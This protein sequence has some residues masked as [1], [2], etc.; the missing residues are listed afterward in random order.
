MADGQGEISSIGVKLTLDTSD[1]KKNMQ[2]AKADTTG[3]TAQVEK[4]ASGAAQM[5]AQNGKRYGKG[6]SNL[7]I[8]VTLHVSDTQLKSLKTQ[9]RMALQGIPVTIQPVMPKSGQYSSANVLGAMLTMQYGLSPTAGRNAAAQSLKQILPGVDKKA[10]GGSVAANKPVIVGDGGR[11]EVFVPKTPGMIHPSIQQFYRS[12]EIARRRE[13]ETVIAEQSLQQQHERQV[14]TAMRGVRG[15]S[16]GRVFSRELIHPTRTTNFLPR[17]PLRGKDLDLIQQYLNNGPQDYRSTLYNR[18]YNSGHGADQMWQGMIAKLHD[19][20]SRIGGYDMGF[21]TAPRGYDPNP[22][23]HLLRSLAG[24]Y[25]LP[26]FVPSNMD[27][28]IGQMMAEVQ[29]AKQQAVR[30][31][32]PDDWLSPIGFFHASTNVPGILDRGLMTGEELRKSGLTAGLG[33]NDKFVSTTWSLARAKQIASSLRMAG[34]AARHEVKPS[35]LANYFR[36]RASS[37]T[38]AEGKPLDLMKG[39]APKNSFY[40]EFDDLESLAKATISK[41]RYQGSSIEYDPYFELFKDLDDT[42]SFAGGGG[43]RTEGSYFFGAR[44]D[45]LQHIMPRN[46]GVVQLAMR[47]PPRRM[48]HAALRGR[49]PID[50]SSWSFENSIDYKP[51]QTKGNYPYGEWAD[52][53]NEVNDQSEWMERGIKPAEYE[54]R[55]PPQ[56]LT[57]LGRRRLGG[58]VFGNLRDRYHPDALG[59]EM[60]EESY[61]LWN[62][63]LK[64]KPRGF[65]FATETRGL[66]AAG[67]VCQRALTTRDCPLGHTYNSEG[68][69]VHRTGHPLDGPIVDVYPKGDSR[70][71]GWA[72][73]AVRAIERYPYPAGVE[74]RSDFQ[75]KGLGSWMY[76]EAEKAMYEQ[77]VRDPFIRPSHISQTPFAKAMWANPRR[78]FGGDPDAVPGQTGMFWP[79]RRWPHKAAGGAWAKK[80][81][82]ARRIEARALRRFGQT[83]MLSEAGYV[84]PRGTFIDF[85][86]RSEVGEGGYLGGYKRRGRFWETADPDAEDIF[87]GHRDIDHRQASELFDD[88]PTGKVYGHRSYNAGMMRMLDE[89][90]Y[91]S[92]DF[93]GGVEGQ[94]AGT[95]GQPFTR[96]QREAILDAAR[97]QADTSNLSGLFDLTYQGKDVGMIGSTSFDDPAIPLERAMKM[98]N[99]FYERLGVKRGM[100][101]RIKGAMAGRK[102]VPHAGDRMP[103]SWPAYGYDIDR[104]MVRP[105]LKNYNAMRD[106]AQ[107]DP[108]NEFI[109]NIWYPGRRRALLEAADA[110]GALPRG[111]GFGSFLRAARNVIPVAAAASPGISDRKAATW[112]HALNRLFNDPAKLQEAQELAATRFVKLRDQYIQG[113]KRGTL[114]MDVASIAATGEELFGERLTGGQYGWDG[115]LKAARIARGDVPWRQALRTSDKVMPFT[116]NLMGN[117][118]I[119]TVDSHDFDIAG[120]G[121]RKGHRLDQSKYATRYSQKYPE[122]RPNLLRAHLLEAARLSQEGSVWGAQRRHQAGIWVPHFALPEAGGGKGQPIT[123]AV[124]NLVVPKGYRGQIPP[125]WGMDDQFR[126]IPMAGGGRAK[127]AAPGWLGAYLSEDALDA[128]GYTKEGM[129]EAGQTRLGRDIV[130]QPLGRVPRLTSSAQW[131]DLMRTNRTGSQAIGRLAPRHAFFP[132]DTQRGPSL[133]RLFDNPDPFLHEPWRADMPYP[134]KPRKMADGG[135]LKRLWGRRPGKRPWSML[136][137]MRLGQVRDVHPFIPGRHDPNYCA[138]DG[139]GVKRELHMSAMGGERQEPGEAPDW[140]NLWTR[141]IG[142]I[143]P[144]KYAPAL[145]G[146]SYLT[147]AGPGSWRTGLRKADPDF[148]QIKQEEHGTGTWTS[149]FGREMPEWNAHQ[150][151]PFLKT[152]KA[153]PK[154]FSKMAGG[155]RALEG[156]YL[157]GEIGK[158]LFVPD[159]MAHMVPKKVMDQIPRAKGGMQVIGTKRDPDLGGELFFPPSDGVII[160]NR[161]M[162]QVPRAAAGAGGEEWEG[163]GWEGEYIPGRHD[164]FRSRG[165]FAQPRNAGQ[166]FGGPPGEGLMGTPSLYRGQEFQNPRFSYYQNYSGVNAAQDWGARPQVPLGQLADEATGQFMQSHRPMP[167]AGILPGMRQATSASSSGSGSPLPVNVMNWPS[168]LTPSTATQPPVAAPPSGSA[169]MT[170]TGG[171]DANSQPPGSSSATPPPVPSSIDYM[172]AQ[173]GGPFENRSGLVPPAQRKIK[174]NRYGVEPINMV[175]GAPGQF[176]RVSDKPA[177]MP[178]DYLTSQPAGPFENRSGLVA[179]S[180]ATATKPQA[181]AS[182]EGAAFAAQ[183]MDTFRQRETELYAAGTATSTRTPQGLVAMISAGLPFLGGSNADQQARVREQRDAMRGLERATTAVFEADT[184]KGAAWGNTALE[185]VA[186]EDAL[187]DYLALQD[188]LV[189]ARDDE[190]DAIKETMEVMKDALPELGDLA[191]AQDKNAAAIKKSLPGLSEQAGGLIKVVAGIQLYSMA[192]QG[193]GFAMSAGR[194][195]AA[196]L[197]D[198]QR[199]WKSISIQTTTALADQT[200]AQSGNVDAAMNQQAASILLGGSLS[201]L[202]TEILRMPVAVQAGATA[203][204]DME[205]YV[206][207]LVGVGSQGGAPVGTYSGFGGPFFE[208]ALLGR[209]G[210]TQ[211]LAGALSVLNPKTYG[212]VRTEVGLGPGRTFFDDPLAEIAEPFLDLGRDLPILGDLLP[213]R[214]KQFEPDLP[215]LE[216][217]RKALV[218]DLNAAAARAGKRFDTGNEV[219]FVA[220]QQQADLVAAISEIPKEVRDL[221]EAGIVV[222]LNGRTVETQAQSDVALPQAVAG[223][224]IMPPETWAK[225]AARVMRVQREGADILGQRQLDVGLP[226]QTWQ[227]ITQQPLISP[228]AGVSFLGASPEARAR[229]RQRLGGAE[230]QQG[231]LQEYANQGLERQRQEIRT[232][233]PDQLATFDE[234]TTRA[235]ALSNSIKDMT[236]E[237]LDA[238]KA[239]SNVQYANQIRLANRALDD[240]KG[241]LGQIGGTRLGYLQREQYL[242]GRASQS[243]GLA[244]QKLG[245]ASQRIGLMANKL[246][247]ALQARS[248]ATNLAVAQFQAPGETGEERYA[249]QREA[250][251]RAGIEKK[252]LGFSQQQQGISEQQFGISE[253]Q[254]GLAQKQFVLAGKI[255][256]ENARRAAVDA[257]K[258][259]AVMEASRDAQLTATANQKRIA[260][261]AGRMG[262]W[263][264]IA[265]NAAT[266]AERKHS[267]VVTTSMN[268]AV[269]FNE[270]INV[271]AAA[272]MKAF[273]GSSSG[274]GDGTGGGQRADGEGI[275]GATGLL[276]VTAGRTDLTVGEAGTETV[277]VLRNPRTS[278]LNSG[279]SSGPMN[280]S[281][282]ISGNTVRSDDDL[283]RL[284]VMVARKVEKAMGKK[285]QMLGLRGPS[286]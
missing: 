77:G 24:T 132:E 106:Y 178:I 110:G 192:M 139:C 162:D 121:T 183:L 186:G 14:Q 140:M 218:T 54:M 100:G 73:M 225:E 190:K 80:G 228:S 252:Q 55:I 184:S 97:W 210:G 144:A 59:K 76:A 17:E 31:G 229:A 154:F 30:Q 204:K 124:T 10:G 74:V 156:V 283:E 198:Q 46:V 285:G 127:K 83:D 96:Q 149:G 215:L 123:D 131:M 33:G 220:D 167:Y 257:D 75:R 237:M 222:T 274:R 44:A 126:L 236:E 256:S 108:F 164:F 159:D 45:V 153:D 185:G 13:M 176:Q 70:K 201:D 255:W 118:W 82:M 95:L 98:A 208:G 212:G 39:L 103:K 272:I 206:K 219:K 79:A 67:S 163:T 19:L 240:A 69:P 35:M 4:A 221:A 243:L 227:Q 93:G 81:S 136:S 145:G 260:S 248:I 253:E 207:T 36:H 217:A 282:N 224:S 48:R 60:Y 86:G 279:S 181:Q 62:K 152:L 251:I 88:L 247:L 9:V 114:P 233:S 58:P 189:L 57:V 264:Q 25:G 27:S 15:A 112:S 105:I 245:I 63:G 91:R 52:A 168:A 113:I 216:D 173:P 172:G 65:K 78:P 107:Q 71:A 84:S 273:G 194:T 22:V 125:G 90:F 111:Q 92:F 8:G 133:F 226:F 166:R 258:T 16:T 7:D 263:L 267:Q 271:L 269:T 12:Q 32:Q 2:A 232:Y 188:D 23:N 119:R 5:R 18:S 205:N 6:G 193:L 68:L 238:Q 254:F 40:R 134:G 281:I 128:L 191:E 3:F 277:A 117:E 169:A 50:R 56:L 66:I 241:L 135:F 242:T 203:A 99:A 276:G 180:P 146:H 177:L 143:H 171:A 213:E 130:G 120:G 286:Y 230:L 47:R 262:A 211:A 43:P 101:G 64:K 11:S 141:P 85:S 104:E 34:M 72:E 246:S 148:W 109:G 278:M 28:R 261:A 196:D 209:T 51:G 199:G 102:G 234:A 259:I 174:T 187:R 250:I 200:K 160:P 26:A 223:L 38:D 202:G 89:G 42:T 214:T 151:G 155:G 179:P 1:Y 147:Y 182:Q 157:V 195:A 122:G 268:A 266:R 239:A 87:G 158:E 175:Y 21:P 197:V 29:Q 249:R 115:I 20:N 161:L 265:G 37:M 41:P 170:P 53:W 165:E 280:L 270:G 150:Q 142:D 231:R 116:R 284:A 235:T 49:P 275:T 61:G 94:V 129:A 137:E 138:Y 244:S